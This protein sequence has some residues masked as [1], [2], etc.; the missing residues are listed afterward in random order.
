[1]RYDFYPISRIL[2]I[3]SATL[4]SAFAASHAGEAGSSTGSESVF[5]LGPKGDIYTDNWRQGPST[6]TRTW[7]AA[8]D[9]F[10]FTWNTPSGYDQ[11]GRIGKNTRSP[12]VANVKVDDIRSNCIMSATA[13]MKTLGNGGFVWGIYGWTGTANSH[14]ARVNEFYVMFQNTF[15][16]KPG[17]SGFIDIGSVDIDG[18]KFDCV[19]NL[20]MPWDP[21]RNQYIAIVKSGPWATLKKAPWTG[22]FSVDIKKVLAYFRQNGLPN[23]L[24]VDL[25]W[26]VEGNSG[27]SGSIMMSNLVIPDLMPTGTALFNPPA[28]RDNPAWQAGTRIFALNGQALSA[29]PPSRQRP[30]SGIRIFTG[31]DVGYGAAIGI[32]PSSSGLK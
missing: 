20:N 3:A 29:Y 13:N 11:I 19:K 6:G 27:T 25:T 31:S 17:T 2:A 26:H 5:N 14:S 4:L 15:N 28:R 16:T 32:F 9:S 22:D 1:M 7:N 12:G 21:T 8:A 10:S 24:V 23:E 30:N 18:V